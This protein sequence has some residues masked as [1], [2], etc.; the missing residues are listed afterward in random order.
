VKKKAFQKRQQQSKIETIEEKTIFSQYFF[1]S[2]LLY[3]FAP[4][5]SR[6]ILQNLLQ[7]TGAYLC[8][9]PSWPWVPCLCAT[10]GSLCWAGC[11]LQRH[12]TST[13]EPLWDSTKFSMAVTTIPEDKVEHSE[14]RV[15]VPLFSLELKLIVLNIVKSWNGKRIVLLQS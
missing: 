1:H 15:E 4:T 12:L 9:Y 10:S 8:Q 6:L 14:C 11:M 3:E 13:Q 2:L 7:I 5:K